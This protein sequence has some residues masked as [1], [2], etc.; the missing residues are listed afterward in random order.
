M[1]DPRSA[2]K[3]VLV[4]NGDCIVS[5]R[6]Q[7]ADDVL[8][9][10]KIVAVADGAEGPGAV[11]HIAVALCVKHARNGCVVLVDLGV[12]AWKWKIASPSFLM[13]ATAHA[14]PNEMAWVKVCADFGA[15]CLTELKQ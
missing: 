13:T 14:L 15:Y 5:P 2:H 7:I 12:F 6:R 8:P 9:V 1:K 10:N 3:S 4:L 11:E